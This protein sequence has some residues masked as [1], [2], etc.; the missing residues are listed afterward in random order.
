MGSDA[1][2]LYAG[3]P[4]SGSLPMSLPCPPLL[5][6]ALALCAAPL[7]QAMDANRKVPAPSEDSVRWPSPW[8]TAG[9]RLVYD[10]RSSGTRKRAGR[11]YGIEGAWVQEIR[12]NPDQAP[13]G[14]QVWSTRGLE[15]TFGES[16]PDDVRAIVTATSQAPVERSLE[17]ALDADGAVTS[18]SNL[19][20]VAA[21]VRAVFNRSQ[22]EGMVA[23]LAAIEDPA[24]RVTAEIAFKGA[25]QR[26]ATLL[27]SDEVV[28]GLM[29]Q[30]PTAY[31]F[32]GQGDVPAG[33]TL[34]YDDVGPNPL[35]DE[36]FPMQGSLRLSP[37]GP[38][39]AD[40]E[41]VWELRLHPTRATPVLVALVE[42]VAGQPMSKAE[43]A[44]VPETVDFSFVTRYRID[45]ATGAVRWMQRTE[46]RKLLDSSEVT[47]ITFT[48]R[49]PG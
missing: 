42:K 5:M 22:D 2:T 14:G 37:P 41:M 46:T 6:F 9:T 18:L 17:L 33:E 8:A 15:L 47:V 13:H 38:A 16:A 28:S 20:D 32:P 3:G 48:L 31:N 29:L 7:A 26:M 12:A 10:V 30:L 4:V 24:A 11:E 49:E 25:R 19:P 43:L 35:G 1:R 23:R 27:A 39:G 34:T 21:Q 45:P 40:L 36:P 44:R